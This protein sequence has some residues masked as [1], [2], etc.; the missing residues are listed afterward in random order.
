[1]KR[2]FA[3]VACVML[4]LVFAGGALAAEK[5]WKLAHIRPEGT[6]IDVALKDFVKQVKEKTAGRVNIEVY[7]ASQLGDYSTVQE[8]VSV[9]DIE[10]QTAPVTSA[11][12]KPLGLNAFRYIVTNW[13]EARKAF[14]N[15]GVVYKKMAQYLLKQD[16]E[17]IG[18]WPVYFGGIVLT[19]EPKAPADPN[20]SKN[21][22]IRVPPMRTFELTA[23]ALGYQAT[24]VPWADTFTAMQTGIVEG[25][26]GG[27]AEGYFSN[28]RDLAKYFL[29][30]NDHF[31]CWFTYVNKDSWDK[32]SA[33]DKKAITEI[34]NRMEE[35]RWKVAEADEQANMK[36][37]A[38]VG[39]KVITFTNT[40]L[41]AMRKKVAEKVW[42]AMY[43][44]IPEADV[45]E[46]LNSLK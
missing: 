37:L 20:V 45:K 29:A 8:R 35:T 24:P 13:D 33:E 17:V 38:D 12:I 1:M 23:T 44:E 22:K 19:K 32:V 18:C 36:K 39:V 16:I 28:F 27:G 31:E 9:G 40:E 4:L 7:P 42:P 2:V 43:D 3:I 21:V 30:V 46:V 10:M 34:A 26:I 11:V 41:D 14:K 6:A 5:P 15:G 25:A